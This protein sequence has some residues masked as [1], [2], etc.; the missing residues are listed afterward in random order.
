MYQGVILLL[1]FISTAV[2]ITLKCFY[3]AWNSPLSLLIKSENAVTVLNWN[4][5]QVNWQTDLLEWKKK[6]LENVF[7]L[8]EKDIEKQPSGFK[9]S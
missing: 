6:K 3:Q 2:G 5:L 8:P 1:V 4:P 9:I 7:I